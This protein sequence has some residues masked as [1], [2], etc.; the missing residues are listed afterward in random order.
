MEIGGI[1]TWET[2]SKSTF[3]QRALLTVIKGIMPLIFEKNVL[4]RIY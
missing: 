2:A 3:D 4:R 1:C